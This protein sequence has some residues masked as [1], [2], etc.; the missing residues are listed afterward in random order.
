MSIV[1]KCGRKSFPTKKQKK[2]TLKLLVS[3]GAPMEDRVYCRLKCAWA[4]GGTYYLNAANDAAQR[5]VQCYTLESG[6]GSEK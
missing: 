3:R 5:E 1:G 6:W 4:D 2:K